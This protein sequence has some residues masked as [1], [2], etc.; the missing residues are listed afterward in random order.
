[1][2]YLGGEMSE[3]AWDKDLIKLPEKKCV[4]FRT[5]GVLSSEMFEV[6]GVSVKLNNNPI[7]IFGTGFKFAIAI[8]LRLGGRILIRSGR[9]SYEFGTTEKTIRGES[10][11]L[12]TV[13]G[14]EL[15]F[16]T[17]L[18]KYWEPWMAYRELHSNTLDEG[19]LITLLA[20]YEAV[21][22]K[23]DETAIFVSCKQFVEAYE[24]RGEVFLDT[25]PLFSHGGCEIH[26]GE[27]RSIFYK[28][29]R[30]YDLPN[31]YSN[32]TY[33]ITSPLDISEDRIAKYLHQLEDKISYCLL[34]LRNEKIIREIVSAKSGSFEHQMCFYYTPSEEFIRYGINEYTKNPSIVSPH[35]SRVL[36]RKQNTLDMW[37]EIPLSNLDTKRLAKAKEFVSKIGFS[38]SAYKILVVETLGPTALALSNREL[39]AIVLSKRVFDMGVK[40][41]C[42]TLIEE[43][44]HLR[45]GLDD[46]DRAMQTYI[47]DRITSMGEEI[48]GDLL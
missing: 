48:T 11:N 29:V 16:T 30:I 14:K 25:E 6:F 46:C 23:E 9:N 36:F 1:M 20:E 17:E 42:S 19:G 32:F 24:K 47:F 41:L 33:N 28:G 26:H 35:I 4:L 10:F 21:E 44:V 34:N 12:I 45:E 27:S 5:P 3:K 31:W 37:V 38:T 40:Q 2:N 7:G 18:G 39:N 15:S 43:V 22:T 8:I 13:N